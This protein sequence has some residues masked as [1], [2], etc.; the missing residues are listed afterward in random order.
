MLK[1]A[2]SSSLVRGQRGLKKENT[3]HVLDVRCWGKRP[4]PEQDASGIFF[5]RVWSCRDCLQTDLACKRGNLHWTTKCRALAARVLAFASCLS[6]TSAFV[7]GVSS[8]SRLCWWSLRA[9]VVVDW[10]CVAL[11]ALTL[12]SAAQGINYHDCHTPLIGR[13]LSLFS[14]LGFHPHILKI[15]S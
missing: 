2:R 6:P 9:V 11:S 15:F 12:S 13:L 3:K 10:V 1:Q 5:I 7:L 8:C 4:P 14:G